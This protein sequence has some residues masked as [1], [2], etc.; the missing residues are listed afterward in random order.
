MTVPE[1]ERE[2]EELVFIAE[3]GKTILTAVIARDQA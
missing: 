3:A 1:R 2:T